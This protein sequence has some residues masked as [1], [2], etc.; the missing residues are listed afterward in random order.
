MNDADLEEQLKA[1][2]LEL[3]HAQA[4]NAYYRSLLVPMLGYQPTPPPGWVPPQAQAADTGTEP[5]PRP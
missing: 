3:Q 2:K 1:T 4:L 5:K